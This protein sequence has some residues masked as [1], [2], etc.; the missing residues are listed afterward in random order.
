MLTDVPAPVQDKL[1]DVKG[2][3]RLAVVLQMSERN[4]HEQ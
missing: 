1:V 4:K 3:Q 2:A